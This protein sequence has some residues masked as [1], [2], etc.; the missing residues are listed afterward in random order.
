MKSLT[1]IVALLSLSACATCERHPAV[2]ATAGAIVVGSIVLTLNMQGDHTGAP[3]RSF[4]PGHGPQCR[5]GSAPI[6]N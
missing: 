6:C 3:A 2:C 4:S 1:L 5:P